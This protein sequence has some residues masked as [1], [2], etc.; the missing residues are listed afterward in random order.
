MTAL[1]WLPTFQGDIYSP[2]PTQHISFFHTLQKVK[3]HFVTFHH[4]FPIIFGRISFIGESEDG[5]FL[6]GG[7]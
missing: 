5:L 1:A 6:L 3:T 4:N 7:S 2:Q